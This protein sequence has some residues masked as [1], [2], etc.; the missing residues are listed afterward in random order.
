M[1]TQFLTNK[2]LLQNV[3][4]RSHCNGP[5]NVDRTI[6]KRQSV[7]NDQIS[8]ICFLWHIL[9]VWFMTFIAEILNQYTKVNECPQK[10][11]L[12][13]ETGDLLEKWDLYMYIIYKKKFM[14][15]LD[16]ISQISLIE[17]TSN[18]CDWIFYPLFWFVILHHCQQYFLGKW[19]S[20]IFFSTGYSISL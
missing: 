4:K 13:D 2:T 12:R 15:W 18:M 17:K 14:E 8:H 10:L 7:I 6:M 9:K 3:R 16:K 11:I 5:K 19:L 1:M 20:W